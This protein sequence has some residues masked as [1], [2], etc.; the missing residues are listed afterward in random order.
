MK[1]SKSERI[2]TI[3]DF[4]INV[5]KEIIQQLGLESTIQIDFAS[6][7]SMQWE[8]KRPSDFSG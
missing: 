1:I 8:F 2:E 7:K 3:H 5:K 6:N 4:R